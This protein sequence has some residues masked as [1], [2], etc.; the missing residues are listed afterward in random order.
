[1]K[2]RQNYLCPRRLEPRPS[3]A[4]T[5]FFTGREQNELTRLAEWAGTTRDGSLSDCQ[6]SLIQKVWDPGCSGAAY[7]HDEKLRQSNCFYPA[8]AETASSVG[9]LQSTPQH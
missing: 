3:A 2:G 6:S 8:S 5:S 1:M 4:K 7:L 9:V